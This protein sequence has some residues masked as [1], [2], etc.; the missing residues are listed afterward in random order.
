MSKTATSSMWTVSFWKGAGERALRSFVQ[1]GVAGLG[2]SFATDATLPTGH[3][4]DIATLPWEAGLSGGVVMGILSLATSIVSDTDFIAG[5]KQPAAQQSAPPAEIEPVPVLTGDIA[6]DE[7]ATVIESTDVQ[8]GY[9][10]PI[11]EGATHG[12]ADGVPPMQSA[13]EGA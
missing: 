7:D 8:T 12:P 6:P 2:L 4:P 13:K 1:G 11:P 9:T 5:L 10:D 3:I